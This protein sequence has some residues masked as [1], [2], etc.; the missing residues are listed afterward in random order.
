M[1]RL[2]CWG[3]T[4]GRR[5]WARASLIWMAIAIVLDIVLAVVFA[6]IFTGMFNGAHGLY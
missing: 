5:N 1:P 4:A 6:G 3:L 2:H